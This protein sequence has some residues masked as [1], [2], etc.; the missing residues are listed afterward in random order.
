M[1]QFGFAFLPFLWLMNIW[2]FWP[3]F[4]SPQGDAVIRKYTR[5]SA[6]GLLVSSLLFWPWFFFYVSAGASVMNPDLY[7]KL[8]TYRFPLGDFVP[9]GGN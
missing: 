4:R 1:F 8:D 3:D 5:Y 7:N 9:T 2:L 6:W